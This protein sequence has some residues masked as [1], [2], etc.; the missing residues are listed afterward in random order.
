[1]ACPSLAGREFEPDWPVGFESFVHL[2]TLWNTYPPHPNSCTSGKVNYPFLVTIRR[3]RL[4]KRHCACVAR[5]LAHLL[6][7]ELMVGGTVEFKII[8]ARNFGDRDVFVE[9]RPGKKLRPR[10][11]RCLVRRFEV[12]HNN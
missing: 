5:S 1:M 2:Q 3:L 7:S 11:G 9:K 12:Y 8:D 6:R 4:S 10:D